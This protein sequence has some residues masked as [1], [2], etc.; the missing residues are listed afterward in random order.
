MQSDHNEIT[1]AVSGAD[2]VQ[3]TAIIDRYR[4]RLTDP[5]LRPGDS[6]P[7][8]MLMFSYPVRLPGL[9]RARDRSGSSMA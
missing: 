4:D 5:A 9:S 8:E 3:I 6:L 1:Q 2:E 7:I